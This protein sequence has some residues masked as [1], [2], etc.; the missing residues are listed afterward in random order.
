M[1]NVTLGSRSTL[2]YPFPLNWD[3]NLSRMRELVDKHWRLNRTAVNPDTDRFVDYLRNKLDANVIEAKSG[4]ECLTWQIPMHWQVRKAELRSKSGK[5]IVSYN[6]NPLHLWTHSVAFRGEVSREDLIQ[7][8]IATDPNRPDEIIYHYRNGYRYMAREWGFCLPYS[9]VMHLNEP[10]YEI[11]IDADLDNNGTLKVVDACLPGNCTDTIFVMAH[12][13]H[14]ALVS[15]GIGCIATA[16]E[17]YHLLRQRPSRRYTY[18]FLFGPEYFAAAAYLAHA[19]ADVIA[20]MRFGMYLDMLTTHE[21]IGFQHSMQSNARID[22][23]VRNVMQ[24]H[25]STLVE[26]PY[27]ELWGNDETFYNGPGFGIPTVGIGRLM[28]REYHY[29]T[30]DLSHLDPYHMLESVWLLWRIVEVFESDFIP[31]RSYNG[32]LYL[33]RYGLYIDPTVDRKGAKNIERLQ[34]LMDGERSCMDIADELE[35]DFYFVRDFCEKL[36]DK[37]LISKIPRNYIIGD[38]GNFG[39]E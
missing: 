33:S 34:V 12:T 22:R 9:M 3:A 29:H 7:N 15:D 8:H 5:I 21:T 28:H 14:P 10:V 26:R 36:A 1:S 16:V 25:T 11:E 20:S 27:R 19:P 38:N 24:S 6:D 30:D 31:V 39:K 23:I 18:R 32:P 37:N 2:R 4:E 13:C 17:L 35:I